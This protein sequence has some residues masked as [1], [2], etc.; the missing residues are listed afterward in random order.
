MPSTI[1]VLLFVGITVCLISAAATLRAIFEFR[2][3]VT[4]HGKDSA[5]ARRAGERI[6]SASSYAIFAAGVTAVVFLLRSE[7]LQREIRRESTPTRN[8]IDF[9]RYREC[10]ES[11]QE[12]QITQETIVRRLVAAERSV[13]ATADQLA[14]AS[15]SFERHDA[16]WWAG[17]AR[18]L[19]QDSDELRSAQRGL[20]ESSAK[21]S[22]C[23]GRDPQYNALSGDAATSTVLP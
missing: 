5:Q 21:L 1:L 10:S 22:G 13:S 23:S 9:Y 14:T 11:A 19:R 8:Q 15:A 17:M 6:A 18:R 16:E 4:E 20:M 3:S 7:D 2:N 12:S